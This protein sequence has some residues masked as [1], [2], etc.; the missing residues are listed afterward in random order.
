MVIFRGIGLIVLV[1]TGI[2]YWLSGYFFDADLK[3]SKL[4][5]GV[6]LILGGVLLLL[7]LMK[8]KWNDRKM[9][10]SKD[11]EKIM[12]YKKA[13]ES[14]PIMNLDHASLFFIPVRYWTFILWAGGIYY[15]VVHYI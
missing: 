12:K 6:G 4:R 5:L 3:K 10:E 8:K 11:D 1:L 7:T 15:I 14:N 9:Q 13:M 2:A